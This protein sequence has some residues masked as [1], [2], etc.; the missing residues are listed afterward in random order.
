MGITL[1]AARVNAGFTQQ[2]AAERLGV[3]KDTIRNWEKGATYPDV[4]QLK[5]IE[6][7]YKI[8]YSDIIF[9]NSSNA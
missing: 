4:P 8:K 2:E 6:L 3:A 1:K 7:E 5:K 9:L